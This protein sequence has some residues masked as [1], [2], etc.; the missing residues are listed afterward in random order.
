MCCSSSYTVFTEISACQHPHTHT[1]HTHTHTQR[2][3]HGTQT[4]NT[5]SIHYIILSKLCMRACMVQYPGFH[6]PHPSLS[7]N[8]VSGTV[9]LCSRER[10]TAMNSII[11]YIHCFS[12]QNM[13]S[14]SHALTCMDNHERRALRRDG[15][16]RERETEREKLQ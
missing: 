13:Y 15:K 11:M 6:S 8:I 5:L 14:G 9:L 7:H 12:R 4:L 1:Y 3:T 10:P 2:T 16:E